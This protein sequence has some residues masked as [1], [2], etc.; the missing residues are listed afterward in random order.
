MLTS[1]DSFPSKL[2]QVC[3]EKE[4][5]QNRYEETRLWW[6]YENTLPKS[7]NSPAFY[8]GVT[9]VSPEHY[10]AFTLGLDKSSS[11]VHSGAT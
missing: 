5:M 8:T 10:S 6:E 3:S 4:I 9:P 1:G 2:T 7:S 11:W